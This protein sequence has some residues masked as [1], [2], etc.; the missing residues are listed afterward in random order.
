MNSSALI[1]ID[2]REQERSET[3][4]FHFSYKV[5][6]AILSDLICTYVY[7]ININ[8]EDSLIF[9]IKLYLTK[10]KL[11]KEMKRKNISKMLFENKIAKVF[12]CE[13]DNKKPCF[14]SLNN[15]NFLKLIIRECLKEYKSKD[16]MGFV[17][18]PCNNE[19]NIKKLLEDIVKDFKTVNII[20]S[21]ASADYF[22]DIFYEYGIPIFYGEIKEEQTPVLEVDYDENIELEVR[23]LNEYLLIKKMSVSDILIISKN[24]AGEII[25]VFPGYI[26]SIL[27]KTVIKRFDN[28]TLTCFLL[29][30]FSTEEDQ[31]DIFETFKKY[32][33]EIRIKFLTKKKV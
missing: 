8:I 24:R 13:S 4:P 6:T 27:G 22:D 21:A 33:F 16:N 12:D 32:N 31:K 26:N 9:K 29:D 1:L 2:K 23:K 17:V 3:D 15:N 11:L 10:R 19:A 20:N 14:Y 28:W 7:L 30:M 25:S 5:K 18:R